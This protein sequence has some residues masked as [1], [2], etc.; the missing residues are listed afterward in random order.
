LLIPPHHSQH[1]GIHKP[2]G[3]LQKKSFAGILNASSYLRQPRRLRAFRVMSCMNRCRNGH[4]SRYLKGGSPLLSQHYP[5][6]EDLAETFAVAVEEHFARA[7]SRSRCAAS[8]LLLARSAQIWRCR[9]QAC[10]PIFRKRAHDED[11]TS[12]MTRMHLKQRKAPLRLTEVLSPAHASRDVVVIDQIGNFGVPA[13][14]VKP[15]SRRLG[16]SPGTP[17]QCPR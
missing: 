6:L 8:C 1:D 9:E 14:Q 2:F 10:C 7:S 17:S 4:S 16:C 13:A 5:S 11:Q 12:L 3:P 15:A